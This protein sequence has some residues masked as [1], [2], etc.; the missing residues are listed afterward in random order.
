MN[1]SLGES[2][3][4][5]RYDL[6]AFDEIHSDNLVAGEVIMEIRWKEDDVIDEKTHICVE[7]DGNFRIFDPQHRMIEL[8]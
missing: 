8:Q 1:Q 7:R 5:A 6:L 2:G 4:S 3:I